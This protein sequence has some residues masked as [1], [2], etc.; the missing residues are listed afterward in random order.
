MYHSYRNALPPPPSHCSYILSLSLVL[1]FK[2]RTSHKESFPWTKKQETDL[3][4][5]HHLFNYDLLN[6]W[7]WL[8]L[9]NIINQSQTNHVMSYFVVWISPKNF[10]HNQLKCYSVGYEYVT[11][12]SCCLWVCNFI[13]LSNLYSCLSHQKQ[14]WV[15]WNNHIKTQI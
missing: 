5:H 12:S 6:K 4:L 1:L 9:V 15:M 10:K 14:L 7:Q 2:I 13:Y 3:L 8:G 11:Y